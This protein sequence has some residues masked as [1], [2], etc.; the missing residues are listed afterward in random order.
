MNDVVIRDWFEF[1]AT[2]NTG[3]KL[4][5][6]ALFDDS[7]TPDDLDEC[8]IL[9][10]SIFVMFKGGE[11]E[12]GMLSLKKSAGFTFTASNASIGL[13]RRDIIDQTKAIVLMMSQ[14][15]GVFEMNKWTKV[16]GLR[17]Y[18]MWLGSMGYWKMFITP[19]Y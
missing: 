12:V 3:K 2:S 17:L 9:A 14:N 19:L 18:R 8:I 16:Q 6:C 13:T 4:I 15:D 7:E 5:G 1:S 10:S 11:S